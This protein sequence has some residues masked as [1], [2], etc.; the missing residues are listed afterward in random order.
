[1][2]CNKE[3]AKRAM[4]I[5][6]KKLSKNDYIGAKKLLIKAQRLYQD[7]DGLKHVL[8]MINVY[9]SASSNKEG[10]IDFYDILGVDHTADD[11]TLKRHYKKLA[12]LIH[13]DKNKCREAEGAFK[14]VLEAW[15]TLSD[16][17]N[18]L[19]YDQKRKWEEAKTE[20]QKQPNPHKPEKSS[21]SETQ[22]NPSSRKARKK[23]KHWTKD[24]TSETK[25]GMFWTMCNRCKTQCAYSRDTHVNKAILCSNCG[26]T[27]IATETN[28]WSS[29]SSQQQE[30]EQ[31]QWQRYQ[32]EQQ[33][34]QQWKQQQLSSQAKATSDASSSSFSFSNTTAQEKLKRWSQEN[35]DGAA[36]G[37]EARENNANK[38][39]RPFKKPAKTE[40]PNSTF[41]AERLFKRPM[42]TGNMNST[43]EAE[44]LFKRPMGGV[45]Y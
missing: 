7:L 44:R 27:F 23:Y 35:L 19:C 22:Q 8:A 5:A 32:Q 40:N 30:Q 36:N 6:L 9:I 20:A 16:K 15:S 17:A 41:E 33:Q 12:L 43:F 13:P 45:R 37:A 21:S 14:L 2:E 24:S 34:W 31:E 25:G 29:S 39:E 10:D 18:R 1:M 28:P 26:Q 3:E 42:P 4:D 11:E 38:A